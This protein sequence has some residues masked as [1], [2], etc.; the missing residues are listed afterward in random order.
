MNQWW[1]NKVQRFCEFIL[2]VPTENLLLIDKNKVVNHKKNLLLQCP[3][4][5]IELIVSFFTSRCRFLLLSQVCRIFYQCHNTK[6][7]SDQSAL[8]ISLFDDSQIELDE[9]DPV[10]LINVH[11][12]IPTFRFFPQL[13]CIQFLDIYYNGDTVT[14]LTCLLSVTKQLKTLCLS[15]EVK[16]RDFGS[17]SIEQ[18]FQAQ[19]HLRTL[20]I[21][22]LVCELD[23][24]YSQTNY[25]AIQMF[26][27]LNL[28][29]LFLSQV[30]RIV[31]NGEL[32]R[33]SPYLLEL[34]QMILYNIT[35]DTAIIN[36]IC[37][38]RNLEKLLLN[39]VQRTEHEDL[40]LLPEILEV[41]LPRHLLQLKCFSMK[42]CPLGSWKFLFQFP[43]L[44]ALELCYGDP[45][46]ETLSLFVND[47]ISNNESNSNDASSRL[48]SRLTS[49]IVAR[50]PHDLLKLILQLP[51][52][53]YISRK[54]QVHNDHD[55]LIF[56]ALFRL[57]YQKSETLKFTSGR[58][59]TRRL[60]CCALT[61]QF[62][63]DGLHLSYPE[64]SIKLT[65]KTRQFFLDLLCDP[66]RSLISLPQL[67]EHLKTLV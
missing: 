47:L 35:V 5:I 26:F 17:V 65:R 30:N 41:K 31:C 19:L 50:P 24:A 8:H 61:R 39:G 33:R 48:R 54:F 37:Q 11:P 29:C 3:P 2:R 21:L 22:N 16:L 14:M 6:L 51:N 4:C 27:R 34:K 49:F 59:E 58:K 12:K 55:Q 53:V 36:E 67:K 46:N 44:T 42:F 1:D 9:K 57:F 60:H 7:A 32:M 10:V 43:Q 13:T 52:L 25:D 23:E 38:C 56:N 45:T 28:E 66:H 15:G 64:T 18:L 63:Q 20:R 40:S 62:E